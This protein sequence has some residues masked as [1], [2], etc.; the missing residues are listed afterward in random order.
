M[1]QLF[2]WVSLYDYFYLQDGQISLEEYKEWAST[3]RFSHL[4]PK[5]LVQVSGYDRYRGYH[6]ALQSYMYKKMNEKEKLDQ[7]VNSGYLDQNILCV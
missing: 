7:I 2:C 6:I 3:R 4:F 5:L 1:R